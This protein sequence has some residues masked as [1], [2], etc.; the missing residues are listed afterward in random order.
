M[1]ITPDIPVPQSILEASIYVDDLDAAERFYGEVLGLEKIQRV[2]D[3]HVFY[4]VGTSVL[5]VFNPDLTEQP[6]GNPDLPVPP[7]GS[8]GPGHVCLA[9]SRSQIEMTS[10]PSTPEWAGSALLSN[11]CP[12]MACRCALPY[13]YC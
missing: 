8:R 3:R 10:R 13:R 1:K 5:L 9:L 7:H 6:S 12:A 4:R 11:R 2:A